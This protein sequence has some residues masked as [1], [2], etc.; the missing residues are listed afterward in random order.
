MVGLARYNESVLTTT[1]FEGGKLKEVRLYPVDL[2]GARRPISRM[3]IPLTPSP[4]EAQRI[5]KELQE[6]SQPF[7]TKISIED[8]V[9]VIH[10]DAN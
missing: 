9:G 7:K 6:Y 1:R 2:G 8:N 3:G 4:A 5:L 10:I